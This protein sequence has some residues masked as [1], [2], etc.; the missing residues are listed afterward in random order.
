VFEYILRFGYNFQVDAWHK[1][2]EIHE[3]T[4]MSTEASSGDGDE[5]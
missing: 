1:K 5:Y 2:G 3:V 4:Q